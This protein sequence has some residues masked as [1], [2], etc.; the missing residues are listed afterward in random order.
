MRYL[1]AV[2]GNDILACD[3]LKVEAI[4]T[5]PVH[6]T[7]TGIRA[8]LGAARFLRRWIPHY[9]A[10]TTPLNAML[11]KGIDIGKEWGKAQ[12]KAVQIIK[13]TLTSYPVLRAFNPDIPCTIVSDACDT[14]VG[15][16]LCQ[17]HEGKL[18]VVAYCSMALKGPQLN[19]SVQ[20]KEAYGV[21]ICVE[22]FRHYLL[23][24]RFQV[25][26]CTDHKVYNS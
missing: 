17:Q 15:G 3:P 8:F 5:M 13:D 16:A 6:K 24:S 4:A 11:K 7:P 2:C 9:A 12:D 26:I 23:H 1:G 18:A 22:K 10:K 14:S 25:R 19:Y 20:E 21:V